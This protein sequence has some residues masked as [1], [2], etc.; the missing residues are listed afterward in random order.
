MSTLG[1]DF[2]VGYSGYG[3]RRGWLDEGLVVSKSSSISIWDANLARLVA[4]A[5]LPYG[6]SF[7]LSASVVRA[8][9]SG[10]K[11]FL[12]YNPTDGDE[13]LLYDLSSLG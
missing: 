3:A 6:K 4:I 2:V 5:P 8:D 7:T 10:R 12:F 1:S 13:I 9:T 11:R